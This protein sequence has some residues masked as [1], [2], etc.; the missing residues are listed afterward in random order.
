MSGVKRLLTPAL[1][2]ALAAALSAATTRDDSINSAFNAWAIKGLHAARAEWRADAC[3]A[4][5]LADSSPGSGEKAEHIAG[6]EVFEFYY[7][8]AENPT[9]D[10]RFRS[11]LLPY[12]AGRI[13]RD[14]ESEEKGS[15]PIAGPRR[16]ITEMPVT[17]E[18]AIQ[19]ARRAG[20][21]FDARSTLEAYRSRFENADSGNPNRAQ[22]L[23]TPSARFSARGR[24]VWSVAEI[25]DDRRVSCVTVD[26]RTGRVIK[27][28]VDAPAL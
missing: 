5:A 9:A 20:L 28:I 11:P 10:Y 1:A 22:S 2:A 3:L 25:F 23:Y 17:L 24:E 8:S 26:A 18:R 4:A 21:A 27:K 13:R 14:L 6:G 19:I 12:E 7:Y 15:G 16:C